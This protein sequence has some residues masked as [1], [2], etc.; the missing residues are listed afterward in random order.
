[1]SY[2]LNLEALS[3]VYALPSAVVDKHIKLSGAIQLKVLLLG[4]K[5]PG[6]IDEQELADVLSIPL[7][8][9]IDALNYWS[10][11]GIIDTPVKAEAEVEAKPT[12]AKKAEKP[13]KKVVIAEAVKPTREEVARRGNE[14]KEVA[15]LLREAQMRLTRPLKPNEAST[16]VWLFDDEGMNASVLL[17]LISFAH[18]EGKDNIGFIEKT[19]VKWLNDGV[20]NT[21]EAEQKIRHYYDMKSSWGIVE[22]AMGIPHRMPSENEQK[23]AYT[24]VCEYQ[25]T[26]DMLRAAYNACIDATSKFSVPYINKVL[27]GWY[28]AG[29]RNPLDLRKHLA[30]TAEGKQKK[31]ENDGKATFNV[32]LFNQSLND[33]PK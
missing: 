21:N 2:K 31:K 22:K 14:S 5:N 26:H 11:L 7:P 16:L 25:Y 17:L 3:G 4:L 6:N 19:A 8:D 23:L 15:F 12:T 20:S 13:Q 33:L 28:K 29:V 30:E 32:N 10:D 9:V 27:S 24:W 1:M 18:A